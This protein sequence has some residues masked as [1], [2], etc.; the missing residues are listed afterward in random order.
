MP[1]AASK[2]VGHTALEI[3]QQ[4]TAQIV[5]AHACTMVVITIDLGIINLQALP[6]ALLR[7]K[8]DSY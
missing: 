3:R 5:F 2:Y 1:A 4:A 8:A 6:A 7:C